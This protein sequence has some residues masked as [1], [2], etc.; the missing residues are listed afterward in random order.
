MKNLFFKA[1]LVGASLAGGV[2]FGAALIFSAPLVVAMIS[3]FIITVV[4]VVSLY[5]AC[6]LTERMNIPA[7]ASNS[8]YPPRRRSNAQQLLDGHTVN[9]PAVELVRDSERAP[10]FA[11][12][13]VS[14]T[15]ILPQ[16]QQ[17][18]KLRFNARSRAGEKELTQ[19][20]ETGTA[21][22]NSDAP[23]T[24]FGSSLSA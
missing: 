18:F 7:P 3:A 20:T 23:T 14:C 16:E 22:T 15:G 13:T 17:G 9:Q 11:S 24:N 12:K 8:N 2:T 1:S 19:Q 5:V 10:E 6:K 21:L 4:G